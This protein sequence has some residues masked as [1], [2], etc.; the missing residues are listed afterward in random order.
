M[1][2][3]VPNGHMTDDVSEVL[4]LRESLGMFGREI[5]SLEKSHGIGRTPCSYERYL[6]CCNFK[7]RNK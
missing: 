1:A 6:V 3:G 2:Y 5:G 4:M 7:L